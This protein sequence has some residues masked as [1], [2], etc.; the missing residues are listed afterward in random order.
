MPLMNLKNL[1]TIPN[2][3]MAIAPQGCTD[4]K[5]AYNKKFVEFD[6]EDCPFWQ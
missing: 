4:R 6:F 2:F 5:F 1:T 3:D